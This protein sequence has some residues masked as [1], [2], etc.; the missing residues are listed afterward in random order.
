MGGKVPAPE[1]KITKIQRAA[2]IGLLLTKSRRRELG[3]MFEDIV[4]SVQRMKF[5]FVYAL[6]F[7]SK[8]SAEF[9]SLIATVFC[10]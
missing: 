10:F 3:A 9:Q 8:N 1:K 2:P 4:P 6:W 7:W 5:S